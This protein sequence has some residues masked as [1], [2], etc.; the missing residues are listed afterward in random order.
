MQFQLFDYD[1]IVLA[2]TK[3]HK[4][5][6][7]NHGGRHHPAASM[8]HRSWRRGIQQSADIMCNKVMQLKLK[9]FINNSIY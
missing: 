8:V 6:P 9:L 1:K 2:S 4:P 7:M 3:T 5:P